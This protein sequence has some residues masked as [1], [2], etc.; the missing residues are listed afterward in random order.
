VMMA[1]G[2]GVPAEEY[3]SELISEP[4]SDKKGEVEVESNK[5]KESPWTP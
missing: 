1:S 4:E 2:D 5:T 3:E